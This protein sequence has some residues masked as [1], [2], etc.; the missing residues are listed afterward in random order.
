M[1]C[2]LQGSLSKNSL[3]AELVSG[4]VDTLITRFYQKLT[5]LWPRPGHSRPDPDN[6]GQTKRA[7]SRPD[8]A[9]QTCRNHRAC[10]T[11]RPNGG[12]TQGR[13]SRP[14]ASQKQAGS[15]RDAHK[16]PRLC[17]KISQKQANQSKAEAGQ[18]QAKRRQE[19]GGKSRNH[20]ACAQK[21]AR[22][23]AGKAGQKQSKAG[24]A[25]ARNRR[26]VRKPPRLC[27]K[28]GPRK[29]GN[30]RQKGPTNSWRSNCLPNQIF[31]IV[32]FAW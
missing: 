2:K 15:K 27:T 13:Q 19:T 16:T 1:R 18:E 26:K 23:K 9:G 28:V 32:Q 20:R 22:N 21:Q 25:Q 29:A 5:M 3:G 31:N 4:K 17:T 10:A 12:Q 7:S 8:G 14:R 11:K 24:Q 6:I 30:R